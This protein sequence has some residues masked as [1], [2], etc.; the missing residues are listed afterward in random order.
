MKIK[1]RN[2][3]IY[4]DD[5]IHNSQNIFYGQGEL[6][7]IP[8]KNCWRSPTGK[9]YYDK[10]LAYQHAKQLDAYYKANALLRKWR[11]NNAV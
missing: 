8:H 7:Y 2:R 6:V 4:V 10:A 11:Q 1:D 3:K 5:G 9:E